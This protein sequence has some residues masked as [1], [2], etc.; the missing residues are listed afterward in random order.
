MIAK[1]GGDTVREWT[2]AFLGHILSTPDIHPQESNEQLR[3]QE[4]PPP[5]E[6]NRKKPPRS[7]HAPDLLIRPIAQILRRTHLQSA[8]TSYSIQNS[9]SQECSFAA[10]STVPITS[11]TTTQAATRRWL[12]L[13]P[14]HPCPAGPLGPPYA[15]PRRRG[16]K[17]REFAGC[18]PSRSAGRDRWLRT[19]A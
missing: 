8:R 19:R 5:M 16:P 14:L 2:S 7:V 12:E 6:T 1:F 10:P 15:T 17:T 13:P 4:P 9:G 18:T 3:R 11:F